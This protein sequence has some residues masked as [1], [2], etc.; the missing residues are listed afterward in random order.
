MNKKRIVSM[1]IV[2]ALSLASSISIHE[3]AYAKSTSLTGLAKYMKSKK[4]ISGKKV[5]KDA[6]LIGAKNGVSYNGVELYEFKKSSK[7]YKKMVSTK[8]VTL[9]DMGIKFKVNA[10]NGKFALILG[11]NVKNKSKVIRTFKKYK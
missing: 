4:V 6:S 9:K 2:L 8:N 5:K 7:A 10:I 3:T 11:D 1:L